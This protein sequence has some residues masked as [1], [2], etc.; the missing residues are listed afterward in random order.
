MRTKKTIPA[1]LGVLAA[2]SCVALAQGPAG[3]RI[4][5]TFDRPV[6]VGSQTLPAGEYT[7]Q[8]VT[9]ASNP[10]VLEFTSDNGTKLKATVT[11]IPI[12]QNTAPSETKVVLEDEGGGARLSKIWVQGRNYGYAFPGEAVPA[13]QS[14]TA[15]ARLE[16]NFSAPAPA[17]AEPVVVA[18]AQ[19]REE[20]QPQAQAPAPEPA[21]APQAQ[22]PAEPAPAPQPAPEPMPATDLGWVEVTLAGLSLCAAGLI[23]YRYAGR[24]TA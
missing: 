20:P 6:Q 13:S 24:K 1:A 10:R 14:G 17:P 9:S 16:G 3:E 5:V 7:I 23:L 18:Q 12:L 11:A 22:P 2:L 8:Q 19:P 15:S 4:Q 21:P